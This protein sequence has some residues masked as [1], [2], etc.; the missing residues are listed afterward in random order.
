[1]NDGF[2]VMGGCVFI[3]FGLMHVASAI[4]RIT[5]DHKFQLTEFHNLIKQWHKEHHE[6]RDYY[7][8]LRPKDPSETRRDDSPGGPGPDR[9]VE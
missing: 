7:T 1:M 4:K 8:I 5:I 2:Y 9:W 3:M 6:S